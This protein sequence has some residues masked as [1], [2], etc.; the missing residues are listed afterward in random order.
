[1][2]AMMIMKAE[3]NDLA[4]ILDLQYLAYQSEAILYNDFSIPPLKQTMEEIR[5]E[6]E[7]GIFMKATDYSADIIGS[8]R[9]YMDSSTAYIGKLIV[10]PEKHGQGIGTKLLF[11]IEQE[12]A[13]ERYELF[14]GDKSIKNIRLYEH[15]GYK[16]F[17]EQIV[18][19]ELTFIFMEKYSS[20]RT[21]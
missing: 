13:V 1:M 8:V 18:S 16:K 3:L 11:A 20:N 6:Y 2:I 10:H 7:N 21:V 4:K 14:T 12:C 17:R 9:A 15:L 19:E 5:Q